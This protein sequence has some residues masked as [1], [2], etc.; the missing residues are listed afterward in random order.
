MRRR[1]TRLPG[2]FASLAFV[3]TLLS[4]SCWADDESP[5]YASKLGA[6]KPAPDFTLTD[7]NGRP[8][9]SASLRGSLVLLSFGFTHCPNNCP[10]TLANVANIYRALSPA[11]QKQLQVM[12]VTVDPQRDTPAVLRNYVNFFD[13][14]FI[15]LTGRTDQIKDVAKAYAIDADEYSLGHTTGVFLLSRNGICMGYYRE[16]QLGNASRIVNDLHRFLALPV[17]KE[18]AWEPQRVRK[19][20]VSFFSARQLY[21]NHCA[22]CHQ[23]SG[24]GLPG[25]YPS[26]IQSAWVLGAPNR[27]VALTLDGVTAAPAAGGEKQRGVMPGYRTILTPVHL[28]QVLTYIR[29]SWGNN[30]TPISADYVHKLY[31]ELPFRTD[32]W[33]WQELE[34]LPPDTGSPAAQD[35]PVACPRHGGEGSASGGK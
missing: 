28:A 26:L 14:H 3:V 17:G 29:Q 22:S 23:E 34:K 27:L 33:S 20:G 24:R 1:Q 9:S 25:K 16:N 7:Q 5:F 6:T 10:T 21:L 15:G 8:F 32:F 18:T 19:V 4:V 2:G 31:S 13:P 12:F 11:D 30:A 35:R